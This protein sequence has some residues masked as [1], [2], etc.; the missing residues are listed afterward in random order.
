MYRQIVVSGSA[1][2]GTVFIWS[3]NLRVNQLIFCGALLSQDSYRISKTFNAKELQTHV[4][5]KRAKSKRMSR[6]Q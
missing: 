5:G 2:G 6:I 1:G 3:G 4:A